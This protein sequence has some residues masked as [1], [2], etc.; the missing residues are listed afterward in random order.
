MKLS[1]LL[2]CL[3]AFTLAASAQDASARSSGSLVLN[4]A[5]TGIANEAEQVGS[6]ITSRD[7]NRQPTIKVRAG[8]P[9]RVLVNKDM[10]LAPYP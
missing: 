8:W 5:G 2:F 3:G 7:L 6:Q 9:L 1:K 10:V 4:S